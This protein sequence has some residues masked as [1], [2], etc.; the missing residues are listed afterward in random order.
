MFHTLKYARMLEAAGFSRDQ[1]EG[2]VGMLV[3]MMT[4]KFATKEDLKD[5]EHRIILRVGGMLGATVAL[6]VTLIKLL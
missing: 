5:L 2:R 4:D 6:T 1:S 3:E